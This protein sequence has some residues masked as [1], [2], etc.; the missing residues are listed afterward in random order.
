MSSGDTF[1]NE[2]YPWAPRRAARPEPQ[3]PKPSLA[4][5]VLSL[6]V[7]FV[8][9]AG[10]SYLWRHW[11]SNP[12]NPELYGQVREPA[13]REGLYLDE[14][15]NIQ[16][17]NETKASVVHVTSLRAARVNAFDVQNVPEGTGSGFIWDDGGHVVTNY[18]VIKDANAAKITVFDQKTPTTYDASLVGAYPDKDVA[19]LRIDAPKSRLHP[20]KVGNSDDLQVGQYVY[21][22]GNPFG[23]D[24]TMTTGII[25]ALGREI[26]SVTQMPIKNVIQTDAAINPGNS[27]GPLLDSAGRLIGVNTAIY[28]PSGSSAGIGFAIPVDEVNRV[29]AQLIHSGKITR[30]VLGIEPFHDQQVQQYGLKGVLVK[31]VRRGSPAEKAGIQGTRVDQGEFKLGDVIVAIDDT[32][33]NKGKDLFAALDGH[34][35]GDQV[36]VTVERGI[37]GDGERI[38]LT[39]TL[40]SAD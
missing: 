1:S 18:H 23:L 27:G 28:S 31:N 34:K 10:G 4:G 39:V 38:N 36:K 24:Q 33:I 17:Y 26:Q 14:K 8:L 5:M 22:I 19:V 21:A 11:W 2:Q 13:V 6:L 7:L 40:G 20:I 29:V 30:P 12:D 15:H 35:I 32:P 37:D 25:S 9:V 16:I 3:P